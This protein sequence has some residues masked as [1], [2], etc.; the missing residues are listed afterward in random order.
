MADMLKF[1]RGLYENLEAAT[2]K[3]GTLYITTDEQGLYYDVSDSKRI[4]I[5]GSVIQYSSIGDPKIKPPFSTEALYYFIAENALMKWNG[6]SWT[7]LNSTTELEDELKG[8]ISAA[9]TTADNA[10]SAAS[11]AQ[12]TAEKAQAAAD[13]AQS[14]ADSKATMAQVEAKGYATKT[15][16]QNYA[17]AK[18]AAIQAAQSTADSAVSA[19]A[20]A[21]TAA[22]KAQNTAD[23]KAPIKHASESDT[24]GLGS[25]SQYGHVKLSDAA[26]STSDVASGIAATPAAVKVAKDAADTAQKAAEVAQGG[27]DSNKSS[28]ATIQSNVATIQGNITTINSTLTSYGSDIAELQKA[29]GENG[30]IGSDVADLLT[31]M[32]AVES[33]NSTQNTAITNLQSTVASNKTDADTKINAIN[34]K[35]GATT[36]ATTAS[37]VYGYI[38]KQKAAS[39]SA[40]SAAKSELQGEIDTKADQTRLDNLVSEVATK[41]TKTELN[42]SINELKSDITDTINAANAMTYKGAVAASSELP[43]SGVSVGD[44]YVAS[45]DMTVGATSVYIGDL[46]IATGTETNNV[47][48]S[49]LSWDVV[50]TGYHSSKDPK[51]VVANNT[52]T[53]QNAAGGSLGAVT[54][55]AAEGSS[56][57]VTTS[58]TTVTY[59][60]EWGEF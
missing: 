6:E 10:V 48:T 5:G 11:T 57:V 54:F 56:L 60:L 41:A 38:N 39:D 55:A 20:T 50:A 29:I 53:L 31:R 3:A 28:I 15:E 51:L 14:T 21:K 19:A 9:Q 23:G 36:D 42:S 43:T 27:V 13:K 52:A 44:T 49:N 2:K 35:I 25:A 16:A 4:R 26:T 30:S 40:L 47:I 59:S 24:Y 12:T 32:T 8:L 34:T 22:E 18:D 37:T 1:K 45:K 58:G 17:N 7:Q 46:L 33:T